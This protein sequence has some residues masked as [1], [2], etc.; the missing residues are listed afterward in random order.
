MVVA[1]MTAH[2]SAVQASFPSIDP[3]T[4]N[5]GPVFA[6]MPFGFLLTCLLVMMFGPGWISIDGVASGMYSMVDKMR[7]SSG[8]KKS[9]VKS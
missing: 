2:Y 3:L 4:W 5:F 1:Y 7:G 8:D 6:E 9:E